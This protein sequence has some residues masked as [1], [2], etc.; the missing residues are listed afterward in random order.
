MTHL[1]DSG[2]PNFPACGIFDKFQISLPRYK[3]NPLCRG[4]KYF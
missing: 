2:F 4:M 1:N 3:I